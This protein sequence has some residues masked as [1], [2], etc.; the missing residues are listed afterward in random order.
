MVR[1]IYLCENSA[2][3]IFSAIYRAYEEGYPHEHNEVVIDTEGRNM[4]LFCEYHTVVTNFEHAVKVACTIR[5]K[6]SFIAA[7]A[8]MK[9]RRRMLFTGLC[10]KDFGWE[11]RL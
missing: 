7:A 3:G 11:G 4:E 6:I 10:R 8:L 1:H 5:R 9:R 2:E